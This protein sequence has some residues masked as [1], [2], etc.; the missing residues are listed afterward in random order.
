MG[1]YAS[2][3]GEYV[4]SLIPIIE[5]NKPYPKEYQPAQYPAMFVTLGRKGG[6]GQM[7]NKNGFIVGS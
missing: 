6:V 4:A 5:R 2:N 1:Y 7:P 3:Q